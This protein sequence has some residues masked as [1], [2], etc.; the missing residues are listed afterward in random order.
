MDCPREVDPLLELA[1]SVD[2]PGRRS[3]LDDVRFTLA[4]GEIAGLIGASGSGKSTLALTVP[5]LLELRGGI[6]RGSIRFDGCELMS[7]SQRELRSIRGKAIGLVLQNP[8]SALNPAL[9]LETQL[10]E[11]WR[12]NSGA[13]WREA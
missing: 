5:R 9:R 13:S 12:A 8:V 11:V 1:V 6:V 7:C 2:Y 3:V 4:R 10:R